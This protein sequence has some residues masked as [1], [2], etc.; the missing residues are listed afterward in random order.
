MNYYKISNGT[1]QS[2]NAHL[3]DGRSY[4]ESRMEICGSYLTS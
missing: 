4:E 3:V 1:Y 2:V